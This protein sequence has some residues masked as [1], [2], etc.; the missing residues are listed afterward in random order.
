MARFAIKYAP[1]DVK[2]VDLYR[3][4]AIKSRTF[5]TTARIPITVVKISYDVIF[6]PTIPG[7]V[8]FNVPLVVFSGVI[9]FGFPFIFYFA[10][11]LLL[12]MCLLN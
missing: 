5:E 2:I 6:V 7:K 9:I 3:T 12:N 10:L 8:S 4:I 1:L 11:K